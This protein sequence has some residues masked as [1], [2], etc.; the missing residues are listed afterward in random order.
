MSSFNKASNRKSNVLDNTKVKKHIDA[1]Y[2][3]IAEVDALAVK[4]IDLNLEVTDENV[5]EI[6]LQV[7]GKELDSMERFLLMGKLESHVKESNA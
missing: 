1:V 6:V 3:I 2:K 7:T 4:L 5:D